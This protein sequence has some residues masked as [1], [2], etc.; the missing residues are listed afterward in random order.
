MN[1]KTKRI[2]MITLDKHTGLTYD[3]VYLL[4]EAVSFTK[5]NTVEEFIVAAATEEAGRVLAKQGDSDI[6]D[7]IKQ[8]KKDVE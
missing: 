3:L 7:M 5:Y 4:E 6:G 1:L 8:S 2:K